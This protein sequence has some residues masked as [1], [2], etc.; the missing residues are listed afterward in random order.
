MITFKFSLCKF[1]TNSAYLF[2]QLIFNAQHLNFVILNKNK[3][4]TLFTI[5][6][7]Q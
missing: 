2:C 3:I 5:V 4:A 6:S 7:Y 1:N